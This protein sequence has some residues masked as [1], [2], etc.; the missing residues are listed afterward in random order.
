MRRMKTKPIIP[1]TILVVLLACSKAAQAQIP[2]L[3]LVPGGKF[4]MEDHYDLRCLEHR[5]DE[6]PVDDAGG[7]LQRWAS[8]QSRLQLTRHPEQSPE[9]VTKP[10]MPRQRSTARTALIIAPRQARY[11]PQ[12][13][14]SRC[15]GEHRTLTQIAIRVAHLCHS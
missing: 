9:A 5:S 14:L 7:F 10:V 8:L 1:W 11:D 3:V 13:T 6:I 4:E 15:L 2:E 12:Q